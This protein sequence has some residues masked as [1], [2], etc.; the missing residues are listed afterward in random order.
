MLLFILMTVHAV[1]TLL[2]HLMPLLRPAP[3]LIA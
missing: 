1:A 3:W 2:P